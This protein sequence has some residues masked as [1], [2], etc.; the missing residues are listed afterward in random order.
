MPHPAAVV[1]LA[2]HARDRVE[3]SAQIVSRTAA[4]AIPVY[5]INTGVGALRASVI[6]TR[7]LSQFQA[8]LHRSHACG[9]GEPLPRATVAAMW[10]HL[11]N[12]I[13]RGHRGIRLGTADAIPALLNQGVLAQV[14]CRAQG[15]PHL[16]KCPR[17]PSSRDSGGFSGNPSEGTSFADLAATESLRDS[18]PS[19]RSHRARPHFL[20]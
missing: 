2:N 16:L 6:E 19:H 12:S 5:G 14:R 9:V 17:R 3:E 8:N 20:A 7:H 4:S 10:I 1:T 15:G 18:S 13:A 11:L